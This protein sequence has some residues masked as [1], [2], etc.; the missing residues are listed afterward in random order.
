MDSLVELV[1]TRF[2]RGS[3]RAQP[4]V[5]RV[6]MFTE[7]FN[8]FELSLLLG[9]LQP[10]TGS[11][12][13]LVGHNVSP[14]YRMHSYYSAASYLTPGLGTSTLGTATCVPTPIFTLD[15]NNNCTEARMAGE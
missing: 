6:M 9:P 5:N 7:S 3:H 8:M 13:R 1:N 15:D 4:D 2:T 14:Q 10:M 11:E 12:G